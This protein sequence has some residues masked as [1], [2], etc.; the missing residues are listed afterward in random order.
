VLGKQDGWLPLVSFD[1]HIR[2]IKGKENR[3]AYALNR[4]VQ[5]NHIET[6]RSY[7]TE[8]QDRIL[9]EGQRDNMYREIM[10]RLHQIT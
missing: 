2:Y 4:K 9:Q 8:L 7:G 10:H 3:I 5:V 6:M 1:F